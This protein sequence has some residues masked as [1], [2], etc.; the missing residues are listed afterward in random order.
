MNNMTEKFKTF[1][2]KIHYVWIVRFVSSN[3]TGLGS[4]KFFKYAPIKY[5][6]PMFVSSND[7]LKLPLHFSLMFQI[8]HLTW[9]LLPFYWAWTLFLKLRASENHYTL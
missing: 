7:P 6:K 1:L 8:S 5:D 3:Q 4:S 9:F 2:A